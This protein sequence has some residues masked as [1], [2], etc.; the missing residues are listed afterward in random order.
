MFALLVQ[1]G[2]MVRLQ[3]LLSHGT[4][5]ILHFH[6]GAWCPFCNLQLA[7][8]PKYLQ[9]LLSGSSKARLVAIS[10]SS[11][12]YI[13]ATASENYLSFPVLSDVHNGVAKKFNLVFQLDERLRPTF[14]VSFVWEM[15]P[16]EFPRR[17][18]VVPQLLSQSSLCIL[19]FLTVNTGHVSPLP[20]AIYGLLFW[21]FPGLGLFHS[22]ARV[23]TVVRSPSKRPLTF[24]IRTVGSC[25]TTFSSTIL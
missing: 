11:A 25:T 10:P 18:V 8:Y 15:D 20:L 6:R 24:W 4:K 14:D 2:R 13:R 21:L 22:R 16:T 12:R 7:T 9:P 5:V 23:W 19:L 17:T 1:N 3:D